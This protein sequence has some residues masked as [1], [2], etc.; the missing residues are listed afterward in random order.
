MRR[1]SIISPKVFIRGSVIL[2]S[3]IFL[4]SPNF[5]TAQDFTVMTRNLYIGAEIQSLAAA[6]DI[7]T[8][9]TGVQNALDQMAAND[10]TERAVALAAEI[11]EKNP[12]LVGL[13]EVY[14]LMSNVPDL[15]ESPPFLNY[16][17]ELLDELSAQGACYYEAATVTNLDLSGPSSIPT[18]LYGLVSVTDRDVIL[19]RCGVETE[20]V[21]L[22]WFPLCHESTDG[23][24]YDT[25]AETTTP[26]GPIAFKR[27][28]V[29]VD[30]I[31]S[32]PVRFFN[33]HLEV[34]L[35]D[36][37]QPLSALIQSAQATELITLIGILDII[38]PPPPTMLRPNIVAGDI[39]SSPEDETVVI[40]PFTIV[41]PYTQFLLAG[42]ADTWKLRP[43][44]P[45]G[46]T[47][48]YDEDLTIPADLYERIDMIF[49]SELPSGVRANV[50]GNNE[51]DQTPSGLWPSD[52]T[53]VAVRMEFAP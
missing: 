29:A 8:F 9:I 7:P 42:Y 12:H 45:I 36:P 16:L 27:G 24:N 46:F 51:A 21:D 11:A 20:V 28:Y 52:H 1:V 2:L 17:T 32:F 31:G 10:F 35:P 34:R 37:D 5:A 4:L 30:V 41:P 14:S 22:A 3:T 40:G 25:V 23:C 43:G 26:V 19:A 6:P 49:S 44:E 15:N 50:V 33:T 47:C 53:G 18:P 39:N 38:D 13:Q 48:C